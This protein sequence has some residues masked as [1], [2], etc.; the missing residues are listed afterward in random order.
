MFHS[1]LLVRPIVGRDAVAKTMVRSS[2]SRGGRGEYVLEHK[3]DATTTLLRWKGMIDG[4]PLES[5][6]WDLR[7]RSIGRNGKP[8]HFSRASL[9]HTGGD[10]GPARGKGDAPS[11]VPP[12]TQLVQSIPR[13][14][15]SMS[16]LT[17]ANRIPHTRHFI[18]RRDRSTCRGGA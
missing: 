3:L 1:P 11:N 7:I 6:E 2:V 5:L 8:S 13:P 16:G 12:R 17:L 10:A 15:S 4:R 18:V 9:T 14:I